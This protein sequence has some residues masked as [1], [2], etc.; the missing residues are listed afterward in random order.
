MLGN[1]V[2]VIQR[3]IETCIGVTCKILY[4]NHPNFS[5]QITGFPYV[6]PK[7]FSWLSSPI[8]TVMNRKKNDGGFCLSTSE[9]LV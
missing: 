5:Y 9:S 6:L 3:Y 4:P 8:D 2:Y 1:I 7:V